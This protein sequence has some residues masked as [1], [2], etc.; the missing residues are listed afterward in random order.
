MAK[1]I[2][3]AG[4]IFGK[5]TAIKRVGT[6]KHGKAIWQFSCFCGNTSETTAGNVLSGNTI[7]C[8][9]LSSRLTAKHHM[10][11]TRL[12][13]IYNHMVGRCYRLTD[14]NYNLYGGRG[15]TVCE[16]WLNDRSIFFKWALS[17]G[18]SEK[19]T[20][21]RIDNDKG[22]YPDNCRWA[23]QLEQTNNRRNTR[24]V[25]IN[26]QTKPLA[27]WARQYGIKISIFRSRLKIKQDPLKAL[28]SLISNQI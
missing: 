27:D 22:Y 2:N 3:I 19:L 18:Y 11:G 6:T 23:T 21:D 4:Q 24:F 5:L 10:H 1:P 17:H 12:Y 14:D 28:Q 9:C 25:T 8:G 15:I 16:E 20:I 7:S 26:N 13:N